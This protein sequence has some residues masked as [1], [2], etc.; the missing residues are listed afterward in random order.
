MKTKILLILSLMFFVSGQMFA[1][2]T[3]SQVTD[4]YMMLSGEN[5]KNAEQNDLA[6]VNSTDTYTVKKKWRSVKTYDTSGSWSVSVTNTGSSSFTV[7]VDSTCGSN[8]S[9]TVAPGET[10]T[11]SGSCSGSITITIYTGSMSVY[12]YATV[13]VVH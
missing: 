5:V 8:F 4:E 2:S 1:S 12:A 9:D 13:V 7:N 11:F 10:K 3:N 6:S